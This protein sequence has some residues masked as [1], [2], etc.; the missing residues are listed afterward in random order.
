MLPAAQEADHSRVVATM[1]DPGIP[2]GRGGRGGH[3]GLGGLGDPGD[4]GDLEDQ[5]DRKVEV[6][7]LAPELQSLLAVVGRAD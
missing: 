5:V 3:E 7:V 1:S 4:P 2:E 6:A